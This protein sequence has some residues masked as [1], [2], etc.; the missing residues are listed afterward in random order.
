MGNKVKIIQLQTSGSQ[1]L[2]AV[3]SGGGG[4]RFVGIDCGNP[5]TP[6]TVFPVRSR[7]S[8]FLHAS[9]WWLLLLVDLGPASESHPE[10]PL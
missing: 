2:D 8:R 4:R 3:E 7:Y 1:S 10:A 9:K 5:P 6:E